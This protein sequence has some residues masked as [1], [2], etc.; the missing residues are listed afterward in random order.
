MNSISSLLDNI[1]NQADGSSEEIEKTAEARLFEALQADDGNE[2]EEDPFASMSLEELTK[3]AAEHGI[4]VE[5]G[6]ITDSQ[7][8]DAEMEKAAFDALGG[9]IMAHSAFH[10]LEQIKVAMIN[11]MCRVC[12]SEPMDIEGSSICSSCLN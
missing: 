11:G 10:E 3:L 4:E 12:K 1:Y 6:E 7:A 9:Q 8:D 5:E 2:V